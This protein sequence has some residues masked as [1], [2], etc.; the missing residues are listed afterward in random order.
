M[1]KIL[2]NFL[3]G[4]IFV[5]FLI[6]EVSAYDHSHNDT[7]TIE[8]DIQTNH[9]HDGM[10]AEDS[11]TLNT[12]T[13]IASLVIVLCASIFTIVSIRSNVSSLSRMTGMMAAMTVAMM[14]GLV[15]GTVLGI[16]LEKMF[17]STFIG[18]VIGMIL[19]YISGSIHSLVA[20]MDGMMSGIMGGMM[21]AMIGVMVINDHPVLT[22][23]FMDLLFVLILGTLHKLLKEDVKSSMN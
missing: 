4:L 7:S 15:T 6:P 20:A 5:F 22:V 16:M 18:V 8:A 9:D 12:V 1:K 13:Y 17:M 23:L 3:L 21:G 19:G 10:R 14:G 2:V 11:S